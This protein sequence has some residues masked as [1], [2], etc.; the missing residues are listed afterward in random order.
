MPTRCSN[1]R[2]RKIEAAGRIDPE[3][4]R[5]SPCFANFGRVHPHDAFDF[6]PNLH[7]TQLAAFDPSQK[8]NG[9]DTDSA[10]D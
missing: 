7:R 3:L 1:A 8:C 2:R 4:K 6:A 5:N 9:S 10:M